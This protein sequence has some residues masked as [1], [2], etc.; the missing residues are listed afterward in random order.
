MKLRAFIISLFSVLAFAGAAQWTS[1]A[2]DAA[3]IRWQ[4]AV[5][6]VVHPDS[7]L[8][9]LYYTAWAT[10]AE[11]V[12][13]GPD[14][15]VASPYLDENCYDDQIW[16]WDGCF[17]VMFSKYAPDAFPG[18]ESL[19]NYYA[20]IHDGAPSPLRIHLRDNPPLFAWTELQNSRFTGDSARLDYLVTHYEYFNSLQQGHRDSALSPNPIFLKVHHDTEGRVDGYTW[21][22]NASGM[23][24]TPR[25]RGAGGWNGIRW[26]DAL[27]QQALAAKSI[28]TLYAQRGNVPSAQHWANEYNRLKAIAN[29]Q[30]W[31]DR[32]G[33]YYDVDTVS[34]APVRVM[35][36]ASFWMMLAEIPDSLQAERMVA[37]LRNPQ[38]LGGER[39]WPSLAR[40]DVD[41]DS[42]TGDYWR[43][44]IW[45]PM[46][47]MGTKALEKYGYY[48]LADSLAA[49]IVNL[50]ARLLEHYDPHTIWET[51][52]PVADEPS[53]E[54][55]HLVRQEFCGWSALGPISL[56]IEN[57]L[58]FRDADAATRTL[59]W[60]LKP[61][62]GTHG[63]RNFR[64][65]DV[66][67]DV[68]Y[69]AET[70]KIEANA[71]RPFTL[72]VNN[73][74]LQINPK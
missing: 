55:G 32:D 3:L 56:F 59:I 68:I 5:P 64:F 66:V 74:S 19:M 63:I 11:R 49:R 6:R 60:N 54:H 1:A 30:Y 20:P 42:V 36:P 10:A 38:R 2:P 58:G 51:Y 25:G 15:L 18:T 40:N 45:L 24:N 61:E 69:N 31:D 9:R 48:E 22:G 29:S 4:D 8:V 7:S 46:V 47:Y 50:Q 73:K 43:G 41:F 14:G 21:N 57:V 62:N 72:I 39:P 16:I 12:R 52:S 70:G 23:D 44:G 26:V 67:A 13:C 33:Y 35:T 65:G 27:A 71:N 53:T 17:M 28:S 37:H 34:G